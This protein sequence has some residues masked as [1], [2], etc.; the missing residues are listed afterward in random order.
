MSFEN[1]T[2]TA[3][4][5]LDIV[6]YYRYIQKLDLS[7]LGLKTLARVDFSGLH[8]MRLRSLNV[9]HNLLTEL[10]EGV[11]DG[12]K[13]IKTVDFSYNQIQNINPLAFYNNTKMVSLDL[14]NNNLL[15]IGNQ[16]FSTLN[17]LENLYLR[18]NKMTDIKA[19]AFSDLSALSKLDLSQNKLTKLNSAAFAEL[20]VSSLNLS[21]N[22]I[23]ELDTRLFSRIKSIK[24]LDLSYNNISQMDYSFVNNP[25]LTGLYISNNQIKS[26]DQLASTNL[27]DFQVLDVSNNQ[28]SEL[29]D[30]IFDRFPNLADINLAM[31]PIKK[32]NDTIFTNN[33]NLLR[34]NLSHTALEKIGVKTFSKT[35]KLQSLDL[36][37]GKLKKLDFNMFLP[38]L[39]EL[40]MFYVEGNSIK[41]LY[42]FRKQ[43]FPNLLT[44]GIQNNNF[45]CSYLHQFLDK[46]IWP[47]L[48]IDI[49]RIYPFSTEDVNVGGIRCKKIKVEL[50]DSSEQ[51]DGDGDDSK[52]SKESDAET[53]THTS[54]N[55]GP[56]KGKYGIKPT[57]SGSGYVALIAILCVI[58]LAIVGGVIYRN[59]I[60]NFVTTKNIMYR[61]NYRQTTVETEPVL[62]P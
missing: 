60:L 39:P 26:I 22:G 20:T 6:E 2:F 4:H 50:V 10:V 56:T 7:D 61:Q 40:K 51:V 16:I 54:I 13:Y 58:S 33:A 41:D 31:N 29:C 42:G 35:K 12:V 52:N 3:L 53:L 28:I 8:G 34:L 57:R 17:Q 14:S 5:P 45:N 62:A 18:N 24:I 21:H 47:D 9:S 15:M 11:L 37:A 19:S 49:D 59:E 25:Q 23:T 55:A 36:S 32:M 38:R 1:C 27:N 43:L 30:N 44:L 46:T 48:Y